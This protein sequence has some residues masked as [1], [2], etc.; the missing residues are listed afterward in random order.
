MIKIPESYNYVSAFITFACNLK[1]DYCINKYNGLYKYEQMSVDDWIKG[2]NRIKTRSDLPI[3][4]TGGEPT[5]FKGFYDMIDDIGGRIHMDLLTNG[6]FDLKEFIHRIKRYQFDRNAKYAS[7]RFSYHDGYTNLFQLL[8]TVF[9]LKNRGYSVGIWAVDKGKFKNKVI[10]AIARLL[11]IDFRLK[12]FLDNKHGHYKYPEGLDGKPKKC[13]CKPSEMLIAPDGRLF[14]CHYELYHGI[15]SYGHILD[16]E[17]NLPID[18]IP[19]ENFGHCS[20]CDLKLKHNRY[21]TYGHCSVEI[22]ELNG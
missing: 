7:I 21:Q 16:K 10:Q 15:N 2:L 9:I 6:K 17:V 14:R 3:T 4:I 18:Y 19:C 8:K 5:V 12:E 13:L 1:C 20:P 22:K 11:G